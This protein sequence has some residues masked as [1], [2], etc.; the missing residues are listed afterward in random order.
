MH[1]AP[2]FRK[3]CHILQI[4]LVHEGPHLGNHLS[5]DST[6]STAE[7][8]YSSGQWSRGLDAVPA[9][10]CKQ[11]A[12]AVG[13]MVHCSRQAAAELKETCS[14]PNGWIKPN[15]LKDSVMNGT[16][17]ALESRFNIGCM[18]CPYSLPCPPLSRIRVEAGSREGQ[19]PYAEATDMTQGA[20]T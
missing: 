5:M 6:L 3:G 18:L 4:V 16:G 1:I 7:M 2:Y 13:A 15:T 11:G 10:Y 8:C 19:P 17:H 9:W 12:S 14:G 20:R